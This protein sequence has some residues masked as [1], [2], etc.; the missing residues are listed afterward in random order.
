R[1]V[2]NV[3]TLVSVLLTEQAA[4]IVVLLDYYK[5]NTN[6]YVPL[7]K[8]NFSETINVHVENEKKKCDFLLP[9]CKCHFCQKPQ[10]FPVCD[11]SHIKHNE[12]TG[13][14]VGPLILKKK[15]L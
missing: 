13:D 12:L 2:S 5:I 9:L 10:G 15:T 8:K 11:K 6:A 14:N 7:K 4:H 1:W 3:T